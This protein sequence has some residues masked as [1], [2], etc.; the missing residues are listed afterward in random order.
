MDALLGVIRQRLG[1]VSKLFTDSEL[2]SMRDGLWK[3]GFPSSV[4]LDEP[5]VTP[6]MLV[7]ADI[8]LGVAPK[9]KGLCAALGLST[10]LDFYA[11][12]IWL[13]FDTVCVLAVLMPLY[14]SQ[15][16]CLTPVPLRLS[17]SLLPAPQH[18]QQHATCNW[19]SFCPPF[20]FGYI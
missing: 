16:P 4:L 12:V 5:L 10:S 15:D 18:L 1:T 8:P 6:A 17:A 3:H 19:L 20:H 13:Q 14:S 9:L 2:E 7:D 11:P